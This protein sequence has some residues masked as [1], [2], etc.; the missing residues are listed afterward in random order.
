MPA[1][2]KPHDNRDPG[3]QGVEQYGYTPTLQK[4]MR[5]FKSGMVALSTT[6]PATAIFTL[7]A[8]GI[9]TG[10]SGFVWTY[11]VGFAVMLMVALVFAELGASIPI[12][13]AMY[14]WASRQGSP[15]FGYLTG[16]LYALAQTAILGS[17][18]LALAPIVGSIFDFAPST[19]QATLLAIALIL[20]VNFINLL[21]VKIMARLT[22]IGA[23]AEISV[24]GGL[25]VLMLGF[26][27]GNQSA[28]VVFHSYGAPDNSSFLA[29]ALAV[30][31]FGSW[32]YTAL[33]M[34][35]DMAEETHNAVEAIPRAGIMNIVITFVIGMIFLLVILWTA[36]GYLGDLASDGDPLQTVIVGVLG[37]AMYKIFAIFVV[38][39]IVMSM[40]GN[41][42]LTARIIFSLARDGKIPASSAMSRVP[43]WTGVP[44]WP[45]VF[46]ALVS[47]I[48]VCFA[49]ALAVIASA[50]VAAL[51]LSYQMGIWPAAYLRL[52]NQWTPTAW[53]LGKW[54]KPVY[55][56]ATV[57]GTALVV[58]IA[59]PRSPELVWYQN[60]AS[61]IF[62]GGTFLAAGLYYLMGG[63]SVR[64]AID[65]PLKGD[66][67]ALRGSRKT[68]NPPTS[69]S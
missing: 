3:E 40:A 13:G 31:L 46:V 65:A 24:M 1:A 55:V 43:A 59:W 17:L 48:L 22:T 33:E 29:V 69:A 32:P 10:G 25:I 16:W 42:A 45:T 56:I 53:S 7:F 64:D 36:P 11:A 15:K 12:A 8:F 44:L 30:L 49:T 58:N 37:V 18:G 50:A 27:A 34:P 51:F 20:V 2:E 38:I 21:G 60:Y 62:I 52:T 61:F 41:Q 39:A 35:T 5:W 47:C 28:D 14:Q 4:E 6:S 68:E 63:K 54:A 23:I 57:L 67:L 26:G 66:H 19:K 9:S